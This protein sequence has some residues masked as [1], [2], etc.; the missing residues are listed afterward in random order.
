MSFG[1]VQGQLKELNDHPEN[2]EKTEYNIIEVLELWQQIFKE[3]FQQYYRLSSRLIKSQDSTAALKLWREYLDHVQTFLSSTIPEDYASL[4]ENRHLCEVHQNLLIS[5]QSVLSLKTDSDN[6]DDPL[7]RKEFN[8]L[9]EFHN[10]TLSRIVNRNSEIQQRIA[11]WDKYRIDL[12][13]ILD[14]LRDRENERSQLQLR[15]IHLRRVKMILHR[16]QRIMDR[17]PQ[18]E[19]NLKKL[20]T[21]NEYLLTFCDDALTTSIRMEQAAISQRISNLKA[22]LE[23]WTL[24]LNKI[25]HLHKKFDS[26]VQYLQEQFDDATKFID[27]T[28]RILPLTASDG[29]SRLQS[30]RD[31]RIKINGLT[32]ELE[33]INVIQEELK[34]CVSPHD[35][36]A[37]RQ[38]VWIRMQQQAD[39]D[40][41]LAN[42]INHIE[43]QISLRV[44]FDQKYEKLNGWLKDMEN[45]IKENH[46]N[47]TQDPEKSVKC[48]LKDLGNEIEL[49]EREKERLMATGR[50]LLTY[51]AGDSTND[52]NNRDEVQIMIDNILQQWELVKLQ[53]KTKSQRMNDIRQ[54]I[55]SLEERIAVIRARL[56]QTE[57]ELS[58][59]LMFSSSEQS[60]Y[61]EKEKEFNVLKREIEKE[62]GTVGEILNHCTLL[63][64]DEDT[65]NVNYN[66]ASLSEAAESLENR[67]KN[68]CSL[69]IERK[70][71]ITTIWNLIQDVLNIASKQEKWVTKQERELDQHEIDIERIGK[72]E[73]ADKIQ[74]LEAK[75][76]EIEVH[77][78]MFEN[79]E[80]IYA[81]LAKAGVI[82]PE[83]M[84]QLTYKPKQILLRY[85]KLIPCT[86]DIIG[87]LNTDIKTYWEFMNSHRKA[88]ECLKDIDGSLKECEIA[89]KTNNLDEYQKQIK[90][91]LHLEE[92]LKLCDP[93]L[94]NA[95]ELGLIIMQRSN[96]DDDISFI[97][98]R[99]DEHQNMWKNLKQRLSTYSTDLKLSVPREVDESVQVQTLRFETDSSVQV[100][101][102]TGISR[103]TSI[104]AK[105]AY[106]Y[107]LDSAIKECKENLKILED[108]VTDSTKKPGSQVVSKA[109]STCKSNV[110][111]ITH[112]NTI[113]ITECLCTNEEARV[114]EVGSLSAR[115]ET[116]QAMWKARE[117]QNDEIG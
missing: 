116:L 10:Q 74:M 19:E 33:S 30:L 76:K 78:P 92:K 48:Q 11:A 65:W 34:E 44:I 72:S 36:K 32:S 1:R 20:N 8:E 114:E 109:I 3:T 28:T 55:I 90:N 88:L 113:L 85:K 4:T 6:I 67:W 98:A 75:I 46:Y 82:D 71:Q 31:L 106:N 47:L 22:A 96:K 93:E 102:L 35:M 101:T 108:A 110:E 81:K 54:T 14:W 100:N 66:T 9:T 7:V 62:S 99:I 39:I 53:I 107:E 42:L 2:S 38:I 70:T 73:I 24:F 58:K 12:R 40:L 84:K 23:T 68:L 45:R 104:T 115:F 103:M 13:D 89:N 41:Q 94:Q 117:R 15:Y 80:H 25:L 49:K 29:E 79:L 105:D 52:K 26:K 86:I 18:G 83:N 56:F 61:N 64:V 87:R 60:S 112:L 5:Q 50:E 21:R 111:L 51:Y 57:M 91:L 27:N 16:I 17:L 59:P 97:Q 77:G 43:E 95:D 63:L 37:I 69:S